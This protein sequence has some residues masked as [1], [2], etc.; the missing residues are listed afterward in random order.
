MSILHTLE[1]GAYND[2]AQELRNIKAIARTL[3]IAAEDVVEGEDVSALGYL[4]VDMVKKIEGLMSDKEEAQGP[5][6]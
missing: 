6:A 1:D 3:A 5:T 4:V 2:V